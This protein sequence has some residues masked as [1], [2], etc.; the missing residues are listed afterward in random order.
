MA[1]SSFLM[2]AVEALCGQ[3]FDVIGQ[4]DFVR[5]KDSF[6]FAP[7]FAHLIELGYELSEIE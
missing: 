3:D 2:G 5:E 6:C 7:S 1:W 4:F